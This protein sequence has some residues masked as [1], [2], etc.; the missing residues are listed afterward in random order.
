MSSNNYLSKI[1]LGTVQFGLPYGVNT[2]KKLMD[3]REVFEIL[4][5]AQENGILELDTAID[6]GCSMERIEEFT[7]RSNSNFKVMSKF[8]KNSLSD[9]KNELE[10]DGWYFHSFEEF[11]QIS[12]NQDVKSFK[13]VNSVKRLGVSIYTNDQFDTVIRN[14]DVDI[15]QTPMNLLDNFEMKKKYILSAKKM[16][17]DIYV[18]SVFLQGLFFM[19]LKRLPPGLMELYEPLKVIHSLA[20]DY[21]IPINALAL[22]YPLSIKEIDKVIIGVDSVKQLENNIEEI[23]NY[24]ISAE[25]LNF[26]NEI[27]IPNIGLLNPINWT[28]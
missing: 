23:S 28:T 8:K 10:V 27:H 14:E 7:K 5:V 13:R 25:L 2:T 4:R 6:Y 15:V 19:P 11:N 26:I 1:V 16:E 22:L 21:E 24:T 18:R 17:M 20:R 3:K 12:N 9:I